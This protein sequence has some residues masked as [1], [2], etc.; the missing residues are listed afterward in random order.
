MH[1]DTMS[2]RSEHSS[3][4][5]PPMKHEPSVRARGDASDMHPASAIA[6]HSPVRDRIADIVC[7]RM[8][9]PVACTRWTSRGNT[10][11][12]RPDLGAPCLSPR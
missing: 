8:S 5:Q 10:A 1:G 9:M 4:E 2:G 12:S 3:A 7:F 6:I 11:R